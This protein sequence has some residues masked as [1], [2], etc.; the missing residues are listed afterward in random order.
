ML[1]LTNY[2]A[3]LRLALRD[4]NAAVWSDAQ[5]DEALR[6]ALAQYS[7]AAPDARSALLTLSTAGREISLAALP[8]L[9]EVAEVWLPASV[10]APPYPPPTRAFRRL[11]PLALLI[12][13]G[14]EPQA[15]DAMRLFYLACHTI[16]GLDGAATTSV[17]AAHQAALVTGAAASAAQA[18][19]RQLAEAENVAPSTRRWAAELVDDWH[20][21]WR[22]ELAAVA[23]SQS[24]V[25]EW[26]VM[27]DA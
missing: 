8:G 21:R 2:R 3:S 7:R 5:L 27:R 11:D 14:A 4:A 19:A 17:P 23:V 12:E 16:Q 22:A 25:V 20:A 1:T 6:A 9:L 15:G 13:G 26:G 10:V 24:G 18:R